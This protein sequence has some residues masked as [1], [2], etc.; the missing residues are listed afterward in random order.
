MFFKLTSIV[1]PLH[2]GGKEIME[3]SIPYKNDQILIGLKP[4]PKEELRKDSKPGELECTA[5]IELMLEESLVHMFSGMK[6]DTPPEIR[7]I[8]DDLKTHQIV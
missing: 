2:F 3:F 6:K 1:K 8:A 7:L 4:V 5:R